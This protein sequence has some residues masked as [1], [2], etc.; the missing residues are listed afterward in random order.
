MSKLAA[1]LGQMLGG[2]PPL[3]TPLQGG[4]LSEVYLATLVDDGRRMVAK[5]GPLVAVEAGMLRRMAGTGAQVPEVLA[6]SDGVLLMEHLAEARPSPEGWAALGE[7]LAMLH[8]TAAPGYGWHEDYAFGQVGIV[9]TWQQDWC[10]FWAEQRLLD[11]RDALPARLV[12]RLEGLA[13]RLPDLIPR[14]PD[15]ALL[16]GDLWSGN[17]LFMQGRAALIDPACYFGHAEVDLAMLTLFGQPHPAF[18]EG[19]GPGARDQQARR[20]IYQ[21]WPAL[22]HYRL[23]GAGYLPMVEGLLSRLNA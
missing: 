2:D 18:W 22:V 9:N 4:D 19:Y 8:R 13:K 12:N 7:T 10:T 11:G 23:F 6:E 1:R 16:H 15:A 5:T 21:L 14:A 17:A 20:P 3:L